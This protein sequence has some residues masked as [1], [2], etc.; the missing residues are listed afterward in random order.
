MYLSCDA[1][2]DPASVT[3]QDGASIL[4]SNDSCAITCPGDLYPSVPAIDCSNKDSVAI[5]GCQELSCGAIDTITGTYTMDAEIQVACD[6]AADQCAFSC[7]NN[8]FPYPAEA[9]TCDDP[10]TPN[11]AAGSTIKCAATKCGDPSDFN[12]GDNWSDVTATCDANQDCALSCVSGFAYPV[13]S[14]SCVNGVLNPAAG[15]DVYCADTPCGNVEDFYTVI[16]TGLEKTCNSA[17]CTFSCTDQTEMPSYFSVTCDGT[18]F[19]HAHGSDSNVIRCIPKTETPCGNPTDVFTYDDSSVNVAC[20]AFESVYQTAAVTCDVTCADASLNL[21]GDAVLTCEGGLGNSFSNTDKSLVCADTACG[22]VGDRWTVGAGVNYTCDATGKCTM[23]CIDQSQITWV[24]SVQCT[25]G[26]WEAVSLFNG[27]LIDPDIVCEAPADTY[28]GDTSAF[29]DAPAGTTFVCDADTQ[30]CNVMCD[31]ATFGQEVQSFP[32]T[33]TCDVTTRQFK[34]DPTTTTIDCQTY[35]VTCGNLADNYDIGADVQA[36]CVRFG[37]RRANFDKC[38]LQC[39]TTGKYPTQ[40]DEITCNVDTGDFVQPMDKPI[41]CEDTKCG[42]PDDW[43]FGADYASMT[44]TCD[45]KDATGNHECLIECMIGVNPGFVMDTDKNAFTQI[46]CDS[47]RVLMPASG[48]VTLQCA[49]TPCGKLADSANVNPAVQVDCTADL[50]TFSCASA[51]T[52]PSYKTLACSGK[53]YAHA[54]GSDVN[55]IT[56]VPVQDSPCGDLAATFTFDAA[57]VDTNCSAFNSIYQTSLHECHPTCTDPAKQVLVSD[58]VISCENN[59][60]LNTNLNIECRE[61]KCGDVDQKFTVGAGVTRSCDASGVCTF[62]CTDNSLTPNVAEVTCDSVSKTFLDVV[63]F[64]GTKNPITNPTIVC[65]DRQETR[66]GNAADFTNVL[67]GVVINCDYDTSNCALT[68][69]ATTEKHA[70]PNYEN[71]YCNP[72]TGAFEHDDGTAFS[73]TTELNCKKYDVTCGDIKQIYDVK[74]GVNISCNYF[75]ARNTKIDWCDITCD[76]PDLIPTYDVVKCNQDTKV[77][78]FVKLSF[79]RHF[80]K[81]KKLCPQ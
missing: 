40:F 60:F 80:L 19:Q 23:D 4:C 79:L 67:S 37:S 66:C 71:I 33:V 7:T 38:Q 56:C 76:D 55:E 22:N 49:E 81:I 3:L 64:A 11:P 30:V 36:N 39:N 75:E 29:T 43:V 47:N 77:R 63:L 72:S 8:L 52:M 17:G 69:D 25:N 26:A 21:I 53:D 15:S 54:D 57:L 50:C 51:I 18:A 78:N 48:D 44:K 41:R 45:F 74:V 58:P 16:D 12:Y 65:E 31:T 68:C 46:V 9:V 32:S 34:E 35:D 6:S 10:S 5:V 27:Q 73:S 28:C 62:A 13:Q 20:N 24:E 59:A 2:F 61:T 42:N 1:G 70:Q 14:V